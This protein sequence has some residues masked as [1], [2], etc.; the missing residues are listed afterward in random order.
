MTHYQGEHA[1][2]D[3]EGGRH[4]VETSD[5][6]LKVYDAKTGELLYS[7]RLNFG[8][9]PMREEDEFTP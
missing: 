6:R 5:G 1:H 2:I 7:L 3:I 8:G 9:L 4:H